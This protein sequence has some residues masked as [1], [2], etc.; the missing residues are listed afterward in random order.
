MWLKFTSNEIM[1]NIKKNII[2]MMLVDKEDLFLGQ[3]RGI[4]IKNSQK[5]LLIWLEF[6]SNNN[7]P[8]IGR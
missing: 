7:P 1:K 3:K 4:F 8:G 6:T 5:Y 2:Q